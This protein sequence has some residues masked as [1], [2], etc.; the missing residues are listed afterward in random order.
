MSRFD[1][2]RKIGAFLTDSTFSAKSEERWSVILKRREKNVGN[3]RLP[4]GKKQNCKEKKKKKRSEEESQNKVN[5]LIFKNE[6]TLLLKGK[7]T[8]AFPSWLSG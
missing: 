6:V 2:G 1:V 3:L 4:Q 5:K 8:L 7:K